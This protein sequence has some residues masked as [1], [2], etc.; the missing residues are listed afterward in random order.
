MTNLSKH[1][2]F[3][4]YIVF[5]FAFYFNVTGQDFDNYKPLKCK[6]AVPEDFKKYASEKYDQESKK[7]DESKDKKRSQKRSEKRFTLNSSFQITD[8]L[9][10]G[11]VLFG[12]PTTAY[13]NKIA[14]VLLKDD[15]ELR[16]KL[17]FY[18]IKSDVV[19][20]F[21]TQEGIIFINLGMLAQVN[22]EAELAFVIS[23]EIGHY[24]KNHVL[25][26]YLEKEKIKKG[27]GEYSKME[28][29]DRIE[30]FYRYSKENESEA[31]QWGYE[32][33]KKS[34]YS[35]EAISKLF[36]VLLYSYL[37]FDEIEF[38]FDF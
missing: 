32:L 12:D 31:D 14:D 23:H 4:L 11:R 21:T 30:E 3:G 18:V 7:I 13:I 20:A 6:G 8:L 35:S 34:N 26:G 5:F 1:K 15:Q 29:K 16:S 27:R 37:P 28:L 17:R 22:S 10:S 2:V 25:Q 33:Y 36:D 19:N 9:F 24:A 38:N